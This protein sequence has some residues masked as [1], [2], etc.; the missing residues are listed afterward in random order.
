MTSE[1]QGRNL[2]KG[3][4]HSRGNLN[5]AH[6]VL[7]GSDVVMLASSLQRCAVATAALS[8]HMRGKC[9]EEREQDKV[10]HCLTWVTGA[11]N[12]PM[13]FSVSQLWLGHLPAP[14]R[15]A[16]TLA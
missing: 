6:S 13:R 16:F 14:P 7:P 8:M 3:V 2:S 4:P 1:T 9:I 12:M 5:S 15:A 11:M 10:T